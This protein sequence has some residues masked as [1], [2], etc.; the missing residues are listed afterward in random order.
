[1]TGQIELKTLF[2]DFDWDAAK[3]HIAQKAGEMRPIDAFTRSFDE[4]QNSWNGAFHSNHCW[5]RPYVFSLIELPNQPDKWLFGGVF[6]VLSHEKR[7][8]KGKER[9]YYTVDLNPEGRAFIG[10][11]VIKWRKDAR[12]KGRKPDTVLHNMTVVELLPESYIGID[13]PG[14]ENINLPFGTLENLWRD[15]KP[16]WQTALTN[17]QGVYLITDKKTGRRYVGS[18]YGDDG[19]WSRWGS[20]FRTGGH[21]GNVLL[22]E[23]LGKVERPLEYA[24][25]HLHMCLLEQI[26]SRANEQ[27]VMLRE[28]FWKE[29]LFT[30]G[31]FGLNAN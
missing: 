3:F 13:F 28:T 22:K 6:N 2:S 8:H 15:S 14:Y 23:V 1:M 5:N 10:R 27:Y 7:T 20:Y 17:C 9:S 21:G 4:W 19:L 12:A 31:E 26:S 24:R 18:A 11:L 30:R 16:D 25:K 29:A